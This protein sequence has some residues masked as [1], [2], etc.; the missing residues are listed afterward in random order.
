MVT[1]VTPPTLLPAGPMHTQGSQIVDVNNN[2]IRIFCIGWSGGNFSGATGLDGFPNAS[3]QTH[4]DNMIRLGFNTARILTTAVGVLQGQALFN[5]YDQMIDYAGTKGFRFIVDIHN[6][7]GQGPQPPNGLWYDLGGSSN[8]TDGGGLTGTITDALFLQAWQM[9]ATRWR[10]KPAILAYDIQNEPQATGHAT[11]GATWAGQTTGSGFVGT[12][13]SD[14]DIRAM[15]QRVGNAIHAI[16]P[17]PLII[18]E[19]LIDYQCYHPAGDLTGVKTWPVVLNQS[20]KVVYSTH[21]Y[22]QFVTVNQG[23][24]YID[25]MMRSWGWMY[26]QDLYPIFIGETGGN[27][28]LGSNGVS[29]ATMAAWA[30]TALP[31]WNGLWPNTFTFTGAKQGIPADWWAWTQGDGNEVDF[32][33]MT[34]WTNQQLLPASAPF[35]NQL[36]P[37]SVAAG[38]TPIQ[39]PLAGATPGTWQTADV[40]FPGI[41]MPSGRPFHYNYLLPFGYST[42]HTYPILIWLHPDEEG[43]SWYTGDAGVPQPLRLT[44]DE[45][46]FFNTADFRSKWPCIV[47]VP[48]ADQSTASDAIQNWGGWVNTGGIGNGTTFNGETGPNTFAVNAL[49]QQFINTFSVNTSKIYINGFSLGGIGSEYYMLK[50]NTV[51]GNPKIYTAGLSTGGVIEIHGQGAGP[52]Q[53]DINTMAQIPV[54]WVSGQSDGTSI[55]ANWNLPMWRGLAGNSNYP[56]PLG[57]P[58]AASAQAGSSQMHFWFDPNIGHNDF[59]VNGNFYGINPTLLNWLFAQT[60]GG[61]IA[62]PP[63]PSSPEGTIILLGSS[64]SITDNLGN[65]WTLTTGGVVNINGSAAGFTANVIEIVWSGGQ[66]FQEN[67]ALNWWFWDG[68]NWISTTAPTIS[69]SKTISCNTVTGLLANTVFTV[70]GTLNNYPTAPVLKLSD[71]SGAFVNLPIGNTTTNTVFSFSHSGVLPGNHTIILEDSANTTIQSPLITFSAQGNAVKT[72]LINSLTGLKSNTTFNVSGS[73]AGYTLIPSLTYLDDAHGGSNSIATG[74]TTTTFSFTHPALLPGSHNMVISDGQNSNTVNFTLTTQLTASQNNSFILSG[75]TSA[76]IDSTGN[77]WTLTSSGQ[78]ANNGI[79]DVTT[80]NVIEMA[81]V[82]TQIWQENASNLWWAWT[83]A[84]TPSG[85]TS[86]SPLPLSNTKTIIINTPIGAVANASFN[87]SGTLSNYNI[88]GG[89]GV[90]SINGLTGQI[91]DPHGKVFVPKGIA[92]GDREQATAV[93]NAITGAPLT[94][95]FPGINLVRLANTNQDVNGNPVYSP[96]AYYTSFINTLT[97]LGIV[98]VIEDHTGVDGGAGVAFTGARLTQELNWYSALAAAFKTNPYVWFGTLNEPSNGPT[99]PGPAGYVSGTATIQHQAIYN[100]IRATGSNTIIEMEQ[101]GGGNDPWMG[102]NNPNGL[103]PNSAYAVM[104][105]IIWG[106]HFYNWITNFSADLNTNIAAVQAR[107][108]LVQQIRSADGLVPVVY[109]EFGVSTSGSTTDAGGIQSVNAV[110]AQQSNGIGSVAW[111]W[112]PF[113]GLN[114]ITDSNNALLGQW[115]SIVGSFLSGMAA[116]LPSANTGPAVPPI[117]QYKDDT[118]TFLKLP[119][120]NVIS[121]TAFSFTHPTLPA[122]NHTLSVTDGA[123]V[124]GNI[125]YSL[126]SSGTFVNYYDNPGGNKCA[127]KTPLGDGAVWGTANDADTIAAR[128]GGFIN[129]VDNFGCTIWIG[130]AS[131]PIH[132]V[133]STAT[134]QRDP[135]FTVQ[136]HI[137]T[138][139]FEPGPP[140]TQGDNPMCFFDPVLQPGKTVCVGTAS[141]NGG[142][143]TNLQPGDIITGGFGE[144]D[145]ATSNIYG[146]DQETGNYGYSIIPGVITGYDVDPLRNPNWPRIQ[147]GLRYST[148]ASFLKSGAIPG[149]L[150]DELGPSSWPQKKEDGQSGVNIYTGNLVAGTTLGIPINTPMPTGLSFWGQQLFWNAQH[151]PW[152]FRDQAGG[153]MHLTVDQNISANTTIMTQMNTDLPTIV[154]LLCPLR[155]QH[156]GGTIRAGATDINGPGNRV[157]VGPPPLFGTSVA[158]SSITITSIPN[159]NQGVLFTISGSLTGYTNAPILTY[160]DDGGPNQTIPSNSISP[161]SFSFS[162]SGMTSGTHS[163]IITDG[164]VSFTAIY[165]VVPVTGI[166]TAP[167]FIV[168]PTNISTSFI[169]P[170]NWNNNN[171]TVEGIGGGGTGTGADTG[172]GAGAG[173]YSKI[174]NFFAT[175]GSSISCI[176]GLGP[177][178]TITGASTAGGDTTFNTNSLLAKGGQAAIS[179]GGAIGGQSAS[180]IGSVKFNGGNAPVPTG[181]YG[182]QGGGGA[183]GPN[184]PGGTGSQGG[185]APSGGGGGGGAGGGGGPGQQPNTTG[186]GGLGGTPSNKSGP[187]GTGG[188]GTA[189]NGGTTGTGGGGGTEWDTSHGSGGGGG[190][191]GGNSTGATGISGGN[192][193]LYG[194]AG[195]GAAS[196][197]GVQG[198]GAQGLLVITNIPISTGLIWVDAQI[199]N[200]FSD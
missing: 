175:P 81:Y 163:I 84:W 64:A 43:T 19:A 56:T 59:D 78:V 72:I 45:A 135:Q 200:L 114:S 34:G 112:G 9:L 11:P 31:F 105:N 38:P 133:T 69:I 127:W 131:D 29:A 162:H 132:T 13:G 109:L 160:K 51:N 30:N 4:I 167:T 75:N 165:V 53:T 137:P 193:G 76:L 90:F 107:T 16:D 77:Q 186:P 138:G 74:V 83:G 150:L 169:I 130:Q 5:I 124:F 42:A 144:I 21:E 139:A 68:A 148:D 15:Y 168:S 145:D 95:L 178:G 62:P 195:G 142:F 54:W 32:S 3:F 190:G 96:P 166:T 157:D 37:F 187:G 57:N 73:L 82:G 146:E 61:T 23:Q 113:Q 125:S 41:T 172:N 70:S 79:V 14:R 17:N 188:I 40:N 164:V 102:A 196:G 121:T 67:N 92:V 106:P 101:I 25:E 52:T 6:A 20:N 180:G 177:I 155:N 99:I 126:A 60:S 182:A 35:I 2:P 89:T 192:G 58:T 103:T 22:G 156:L 26:Q 36:L 27:M 47:I 117:L 119:S 66:I 111:A 63:G 39:A 1:F 94:T 10:G 118:G 104:T 199:Y 100:A 173:G 147:H 122:G 141:V 154:Q 110:I 116:T 80:A 174:T 151:Y 149:G 24:A 179:T 50:F 143:I 128:H 44:N 134:F 98:V 65:Q 158:S 18:C 152:F 88:S 55:P 198:S 161:T 91:I 129:S 33:M 171:N 123:G 189:T 136:L 71:D 170:Q 115:G 140:A 49:A 159:I 176:I 183:G 97:A 8:G 197:G 184:G 28:Q 185:L 153:G 108:A 7:Q 181:I 86:V 46:A 120:G 87:I 194:G 93:A 85:G 191:G 48:Y 12:I